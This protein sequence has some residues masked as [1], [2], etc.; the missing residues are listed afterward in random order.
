MKFS[1]DDLVDQFDL[2]SDI[3]SQDHQL[4]T[5]PNS[6]IISEDNSLFPSFSLLK[7]KNQNVDQVQA[8]KQLKLDDKILDMLSSLDFKDKL[9]DP[10]AYEPFSVSFKN[11]RSQQPYIFE[12]EPLDE[13][14][15]YNEKHVTK[16]LQD[17][18]DSRW[19]KLEIANLK[20]INTIKE[21]KRRIEE[22]RLRLERER[23]AR[24]EEEA[25]RKAAEEEERK[26]R[27]QLEEEER[28]RKQKEEEEAKRKAAQEEE[29][30]LKRIEE[31]AKRKEE[32]NKQKKE[33][34]AKA[35]AQL[36]EEQERK[37][38]QQNKTDFKSIEKTFWKYKERIAIIKKDIVEP[39]KNANK[40]LRNIISRHKRKIN[41]KF[42]Q[43][44]NSNQQLIS[45]QTELIELI[46]ETK[47]DQ[48]AYQWILNF[49]AKAIVHQAETEVR[50]KPESAIPLG[51]LTLTLLVRFP[52]LKTLLVARFV[53][54]CPYVI[55]F[56]CEIDTEKGRENM[57]W[58]R[59]SEQKWEDDTSYDERM[60]GMT[61]LF[62]VITRLPLSQDL[63]TSFSHPL[64]IIYSW[65]FLARMANTPI[66]LLTNTHF[67]VIGAWWDAAA[68]QFL[69]AYSN[70]STK[71]LQ[72]IARDL[73]DAVASKKFVGAARLRILLE[74]WEMGQMKS[75]PEMTA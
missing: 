26:R 37:K 28:I 55:G 18:I 34:E 51:K 21:E 39:M 56:T 61:T 1:F 71:L 3:E 70:Q 23:R 24:E 57:G 75:F 25:R 38:I 73:T 43:L 31:E 58:K 19:K 74:E 69:Q 16:A 11:K 66:D 42:G 52:E 27:L 36:L 60:A 12:N 32:E 59:N 33:A 9:V 10:L 13:A 67:V 64:P 48:L 65:Q 35:E 17:S 72:L 53:K 7:T 46:N 29:A 47:S 62:F 15:D 54:K 50:V 20:Q 2:N 8:E 63:I 41:P 49:I 4:A 45:I 30:R 22:E 14:D 5:S 6:S 40:E 68:A 44:T